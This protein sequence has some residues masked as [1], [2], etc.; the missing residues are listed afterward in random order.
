M[1]K[2]MVMITSSLVLMSACSLFDSDDNS[3]EPTPIQEGQKVELSQA[4]GQFIDSPVQGLE[5]ELLDENFKELSRGVTNEFGEYSYDPSKIE[6]IKFNIA[7]YPLG[8]A[9]IGKITT[10]YTLTP[11]KFSGDLS[12]N[13]HSD[14]PV[15]ISRFLQTLDVDGDPENGITIS[16]ET[17]A[18]FK[19]IHNNQDN[20]PNFNLSTE[21]FADHIEQYIGEYTN[22]STLV[23]EEDAIAH[24]SAYLNN[25]ET[26]YSIDLNGHKWVTQLKELRQY[27]SHDEGAT[28]LFTKTCTETDMNIYSIEEFYS[29]Y[30]KVEI[31]D[32]FDTNTCSR[33]GEK[34]FETENYGKYT[35]CP[36]EECTFSDLNSISNWQYN[37]SNERFEKVA[38]SHVLGTEKINLI[39]E[40]KFTYDNKSYW[41]VMRYESERI[42]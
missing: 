20:L 19:T 16:A 38:R 7:N 31:W 8:Y 32:S 11:F 24:I 34:S 37:A 28:W 13:I 35:L 10:P 12:K 26:D 9:P 3:S 27:V 42:Y 17:T 18:S 36:R 40:V 4:V 23:S 1:L 5:Y 15:N 25:F 30:V 41:H 33:T 14:W 6:Y 39:K 2:N 21:D 22:T 29:G